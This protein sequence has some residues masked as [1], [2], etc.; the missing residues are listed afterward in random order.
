MFREERAGDAAPVF[1]V[2]RSLLFA[3]R[4]EIARA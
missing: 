3:A 2:D 4:I 1:I